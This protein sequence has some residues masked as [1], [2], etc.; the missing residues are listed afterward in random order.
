[1]VISL[2]SYDHNV[3]NSLSISFILSLKIVRQD[4]FGFTN[5][6]RISSL[7]MIKYMNLVFPI[8]VGIQQK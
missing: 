5:A 6:Q 2:G 3:V 7:S 1:M 8:A 4:A